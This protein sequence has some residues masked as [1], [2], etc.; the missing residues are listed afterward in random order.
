[1]TMLFAAKPR[2]VVVVSSSVVSSVVKLFGFIVNWT[3]PS[4]VPP[5][6]LQ[7]TGIA[8]FAATGKMAGE[9]SATVFITC[10]DLHSVIVF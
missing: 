9:A 6:T 7:S 1:M 5:A 8:V 2:G 4:N 10:C 3:P